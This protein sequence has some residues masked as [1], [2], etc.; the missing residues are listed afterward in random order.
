MR[1]FH[2]FLR[3]APVLVRQSLDEAREMHE[4]PLDIWW[5]PQRCASVAVDVASAPVCKR[6]ATSMNDMQAALELSQPS[7][8]DVPWG[9]AH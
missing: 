2:S 3:R 4:V 9:F 5:K 1:G 7:D 8:A 6:F